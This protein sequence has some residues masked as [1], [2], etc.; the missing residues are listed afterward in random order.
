MKRQQQEQLIQPLAWVSR[1]SAFRKRIVV[2]R[3]QNTG[4]KNILQFLTAC[5]GIV[6]SKL[7]DNVQSEQRKTNM[8]L[9]CLFVIKKG[10]EEKI[11]DFYFTSKMTLITSGKFLIVFQF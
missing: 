5:E 7:Q 9:K 8:E 3:I 6:Q 10:E 11:Q 4:F 1:A 2:G